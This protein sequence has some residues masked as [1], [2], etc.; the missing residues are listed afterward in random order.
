VEGKPIFVGRAQK[1]A[2]RELELK[3]KFEQ[4]K[5]EQ[6]A[7]FQGVNLYI[8]NLDDD[9]DDDKLRG[10][11]NTFG[12]ITSCRVMKD[13]KSNSKGFG[14]VCFTTPEEA[15]KAV[16]EM[17]GKIVGSKPLY[18][19][20]AQRKD[21]RRAQLEAQFAQRTKITAIAGR[22]PA[23]GVAYGANGA[24]VFYAPP[25]QPGFVYGQMVPRAPGGRYPYQPVPGNYVMV[26]GRGQVKNGRGMVGNMP[27]R[28]GMKP[29]GQPIMQPG[30]IP[31]QAPAPMPVIPGAEPK[32]TLQLLSALPSEEQKSVLGERLYPL[33]MKSQPA[34]AGKITGM[35]LESCTVEEMLGLIDNQ[36]NLNEKVDEAL[37]VLKEYSD[38]PEDK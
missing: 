38:K 37:K 15:T 35:I 16:T 19:G 3:Q 33:I 4:M 27:R 13:G 5:Q 1:K 14:F 31:M 11:F 30:P 7:K 17:N 24:P 20:L 26:G 9:F 18:V 10:V 25:T 29:Q 8:K 21:V 12:T 6:L 34:L 2:E 28:G 22:M 36:D 32:L 23:P